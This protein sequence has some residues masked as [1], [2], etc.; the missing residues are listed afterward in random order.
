MR[1]LRIA[2][3]V[4]VATVSTATRAPADAYDPLA[5]GQPATHT[6]L[7]VR[8]DARQREIPLRVYL[9][10]S[11][12]PAPIVLFSHGLGGSREGYAYLGE[13][14]A[15]RGYVAVFMQHPGSDDSVWKGAP[16]GER[17]DAMEQA[18]SG[19]N[20]FL[21]VQDV[22]A[23]LDQLDSWNGTAGH[24]LAVRLDLARVGMSGHSFGAVTTQAVLEKGDRFRAK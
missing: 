23:V 16:R 11:T 21:R 9:P 7:V 4:T 13:H 22:R 20:F 14:W 6:D 12:A 17:R 3:A 24:T 1:G 18:A 15:A 10:A 2:L 19:R 8:D 5:A